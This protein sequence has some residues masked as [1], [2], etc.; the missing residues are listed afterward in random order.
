[1]RSGRTARCLC[2]APVGKN[3]LHDDLA[4]LEDAFLARIV[5]LHTASERQRM[6]NR[7]KAYSID[8]GI[9]SLYERTG[10]PKLGHALETVVLLGLERRGWAMWFHVAAA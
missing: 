6:V 1:M 7:C 10:R 3:T 8:P 9:I 5:S 4:H 2:F